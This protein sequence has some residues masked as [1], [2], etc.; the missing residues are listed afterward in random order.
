MQRNTPKEAH[1]L[2]RAIAFGDIP[3]V[4][5]LLEAGYDP[6]K[7][8]EFYGDPLSAAVYHCH[9]HPRVVQALLEKG[10]SPNSS[11][12]ERHG[13]PLVTT[14][15]AGNLNAIQMLLDAGANVHCHGGRYNTALQAVMTAS[16][17]RNK[18]GII[19]LLLNYGANA[20][21]TSGQFYSALSSGFT[22]LPRDDCIISQ[23]LDY[24]LSQK[25]RKDLL[26]HTIRAAACL[27]DLASVQILLSAGAGPN[28]VAEAVESANIDLVRFLVKI[29][30]CLP[31]HGA[32][33]NLVSERYGTPLQAAAFAG[34]TELVKRLFDRGAD[35][36]ISCG[37]WGSPLIAAANAGL[38][39]II[40]L[41]LHSGADINKKGGDPGTALRAACEVGDLRSSQTTYQLWS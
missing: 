30:E 17:H 31:E 27:G 21:I 16:D 19:K 2:Q 24:T 8:G 10:A 13:P 6:N 35:L 36:N 28:A 12:G 41:L 37:H 5:F 9:K 7:Q 22:L 20:C 4:S 38:K 25:P 14:A 18:H 11:G 1:A 32:D 40:M 33:V 39:E 34:N 23:L 26:D 3:K 29:F 15:E